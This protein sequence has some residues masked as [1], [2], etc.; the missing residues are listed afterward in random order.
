[1]FCTTPP[2]RVL[3]VGR[4]RERLVL[5]LTTEEVNVLRGKHELLLIQN[6]VLD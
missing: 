3:N 2:D 4:H 5:W 6:D 1:M